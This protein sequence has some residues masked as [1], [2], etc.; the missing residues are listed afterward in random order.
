MNTPELQER[1]F[2]NL[3]KRRIAQKLGKGGAPAAPTGKALGAGLI[4]AGNIARWAYV[5]RL[6]RK[7][8]FRLA[9]VFDVNQAGA[10]QVADS[11]GAKACASVDELLKQ[12]EVEAVFICTPAAFHCDAAIAALKAGKHVLCEKPIASNAAEAEQM[13]AAAARTGRRR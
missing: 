7:F 12:P 3:V 2:A 13:A 9:A 5:P 11:T 1:T 10:K 4:G 6:Q 8:P